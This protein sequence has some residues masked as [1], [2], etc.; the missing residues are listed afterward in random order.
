MNVVKEGK[1][2][3]GNEGRY[4]PVG[5]GRAEIVETRESVATTTTD[6]FLFLGLHNSHTFL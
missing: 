4:I 5:E 2:K 6:A 3:A 1:R